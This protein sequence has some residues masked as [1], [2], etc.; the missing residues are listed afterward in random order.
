MGDF[1][2]VVAPPLRFVCAACGKTSASRS[3]FDSAGRRVCD[4]WWD[5]S[6]C[7]HAVLCEPNCEG[8][9]LKGEP[10]WRAVK[11]TTPQ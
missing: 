4:S 1:D 2:E 6:C 5:A 7:T 10:L 3:G 8:A 9:I 11:P